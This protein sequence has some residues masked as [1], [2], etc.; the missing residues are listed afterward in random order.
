MLLVI[1]G[2]KTP[3]GRVRQTGVCVFRLLS[4]SGC[5]FGA[6]FPFAV[7]FGIELGGGDE[8][9]GGAVDAVAQ[10]AFVGGTVVKDVA[11]MGIGAAAAH[12]GAVHIVA[13]VVAL[14]YG[15]GPDR[16]GEAGPAAAGLEFVA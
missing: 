9:Q 15:V 11:E 10:A 14:G 7:A 2:A 6:V 16:T 12:L 3:A 4:L 1:A 8:A 5:L 13:V